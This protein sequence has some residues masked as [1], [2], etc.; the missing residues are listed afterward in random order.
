MASPWCEQS[1]DI[2]SGFN[3][4]K[5]ARKITWLGASSVLYAQQLGAAIFSLSY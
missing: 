5:L 1:L 4:F 3:F 2:V